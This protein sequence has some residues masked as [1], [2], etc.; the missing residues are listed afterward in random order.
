M[1][2]LSILPMWH[3][4][5]RMSASP[6]LPRFQSERVEKSETERKLESPEKKETD[7]ADRG[8]EVLLRADEVVAQAVQGERSVAEYAAKRG[9]SLIEAEARRNTDITSAVM[10]EADA[11]R[12]GA[13]ASMDLG[14]KM[15]AWSRLKRRASKAGRAVLGR[16]RNRFSPS[17]PKHLTH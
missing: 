10:R 2:V 13:D 14:Q 17:H 8:T 3:T 12:A 15:T 6:E 9:A 1:A 5:V 4:F 16:P 7:P 11:C